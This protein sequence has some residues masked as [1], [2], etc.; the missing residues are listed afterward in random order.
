MQ[1]RQIMSWGDS[2]GETRL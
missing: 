2:L 1:T